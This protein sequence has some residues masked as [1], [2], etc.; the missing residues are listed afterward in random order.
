MK[1]ACSDETESNANKK[2]KIDDSEHEAE[3]ID[4]NEEENN[5]NEIVLLNQ[6]ANR[7]GIV[8]RVNKTFKRFFGLAKQ[9]SADFI[10]NEIGL[11]G[12]VIRLTDFELP[13]LEKKPEVKE[14]ADLVSFILLFF[15]NH[16]NAIASDL[17]LKDLV[18]NHASFKFF[19]RLTLSCH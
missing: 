5:E 19:I 12:N 11:D 14:N 18:L 1:T 10:V 7:Y 4:L 6:I 15:N 9:S 17:G 8:E 13:V 3:T 2:I 16:S